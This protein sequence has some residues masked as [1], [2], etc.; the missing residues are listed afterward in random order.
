M[1]NIYAFVLPRMQGEYTGDN[2]VILKITLNQLIAAIAESKSITYEEELKNFNDYK[3][4]VSGI[5][6][7]DLNEFDEYEEIKN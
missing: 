5:K 2:R 3:N 7:L 4:T 1:N 6:D